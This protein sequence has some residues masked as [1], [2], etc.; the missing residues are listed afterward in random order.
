MK[1]ARITIYKKNLELLNNEIIKKNVTEEVN[2]LLPEIV[3]ELSND[4]L[5]A[6]QIRI[7]TSKFTP[8]ARKYIS[9][10]KIEDSDI[11][12]SDILI[13]IVNKYVQ[14]NESSIEDKI[15]TVIKS[16]TANQLFY[17]KETLNQI[18]EF[19]FSLK[20]ANNL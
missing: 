2:R 12:Y 1:D 19:L 14:E 8:K 9:E 18:D 5:I 15:E 7:R 13:N 17:L 20:K 10:V 16:E 6:E 4:I 11:S 3:K